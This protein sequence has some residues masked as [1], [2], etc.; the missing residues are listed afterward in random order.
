M[1]QSGSPKQISYASESWRKA[2]HTGA[3]II[4]GAYYYLELSKIEMLSVMVPITLVMVLIDIARLRDLWIWR[5]VV[6]PVMGGMVRPHEKAGDFTGASYI[7]LT[8][9]VTVA[10]FDKNI[11]IAGL[12]F[13]MVGD[14]FAA[15]IGRKF[16]RHKF[17]QNKSVE[18]TLG[19]LLGTLIVALVMYPYLPWQLGVGGA[20][21][22]A[23]AEAFSFG[24][25]DNVT[26][27]LTSGL[28]MTI[29]FSIFA[30]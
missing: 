7:L 13:T 8:I 17:G 4:P 27:P 24:I 16:G 5:V 11:A 10:L 12:A 23:L 18:G 26:V 19:C 14:T 2:T 29:I 15:L 1:S 28:A 6:S 25:D 21:V 9:C 3:L 30:L 22:S 20:I